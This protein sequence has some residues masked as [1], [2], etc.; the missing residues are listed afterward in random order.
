MS[1][2]PKNVFEYC[3]IEIGHLLFE[4]RCTNYYQIYDHIVGKIVEFNF[5]KWNYIPAVD[6]NNPQK[7]KAIT[8]NIVIKFWQTLM[9]IWE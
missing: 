6:K 4:Q 1:W 3:Q 5:N 7:L 2:K 8:L 9:C